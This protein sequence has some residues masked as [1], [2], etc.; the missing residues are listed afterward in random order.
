MTPH[1]AAL[2]RVGVALYRS[3]E[4]LDGERRG[5]TSEQLRSPRGDHS[6]YVARVG[7]AS[8]RVTKIR[9]QRD[10]LLLIN[11]LRLFGDDEADSA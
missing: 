9:K 10:K 7:L 3:L 2:E 8:A 1:Q 11:N 5:L 4:V 6:Y